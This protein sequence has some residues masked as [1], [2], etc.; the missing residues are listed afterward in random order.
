MCGDSVKQSCG[1]CPCGV[2]IP[3]RCHLVVPQHAGGM[4]YGEHHMMTDGYGSMNEAY[5]QLQVNR[6]P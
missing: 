1:H 4:S 6:S 2:T 5:S 3:S